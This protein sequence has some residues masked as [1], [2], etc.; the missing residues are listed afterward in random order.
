[1]G[2]MLLIDSKMGVPSA[3]NTSMMRKRCQG[4]GLP[5]QNLTSSITASV[6]VE[7]SAGYALHHN[8]KHQAEL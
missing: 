3:S 8:D 5:K 4:Y 1:M 2:V 7:I 6:N